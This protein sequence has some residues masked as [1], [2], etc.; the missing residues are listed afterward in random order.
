M[1]ERESGY[2]PDIDKAQDMAKA[3]KEARDMADQHRDWNPPAAEVADKRADRIEN[4]QGVIY[5]VDQAVQGMNLEQIT[6]MSDQVARDL[7]DVK[8]E[9]DRQPQ[10]ETLKKKYAELSIKN[11]RLSQIIEDPR[12]LRPAA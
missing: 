6:E 5:E 10:D 9:L 11:F 3:G 4:E 1:P 8:D 7:A 2:I 12:L